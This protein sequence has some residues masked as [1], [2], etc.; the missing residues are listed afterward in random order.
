MGFKYDHHA[1]AIL[2]RGSKII[3]S[4][5][6]TIEELQFSKVFKTYA[7]LNADDLKKLIASEAK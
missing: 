4:L 7:E 6:K 2:E 1:F 3:D 5:P